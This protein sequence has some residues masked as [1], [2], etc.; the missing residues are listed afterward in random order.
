MARRIFFSRHSRQSAFEAERQF[1]ELSRA[2]RA[3]RNDLPT[4]RTRLTNVP[5][6]PRSRRRYTYV[7]REDISPF[8][9]FGAKT[10]GRTFGNLLTNELDLTDK[11][12]F[13]PTRS[14]LTS[15]L[16]SAIGKAQR[17]R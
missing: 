16:W 15:D 4:L 5:T 1:T 7:E 11:E 13:W 17:I 14:Q 9:G 3:L 10:V 2:M 6:I 8:I 12:S